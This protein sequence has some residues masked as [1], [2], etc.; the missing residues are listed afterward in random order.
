MKDNCV[1]CGKE[2]PY[3]VTTHIDMRSN[4]VEGVGQLCVNCTAI[5]RMYP[6][7]PNM[8]HLKHL[9]VPLHL[10]K[11]TSNDAELG[12]KVRQLFYN[13]ED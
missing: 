12:A 6:E 5:G 7:S 1:M 10:I 9:L 3:D 8:D 11:N 4:Y 2:T 13:I